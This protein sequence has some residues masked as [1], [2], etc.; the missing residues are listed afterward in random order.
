MTP[1]KCKLPQL[2]LLL[3]QK[4]V[5]ALN[6][7]FQTINLRMEQDARGDCKLTPSEV[8]EL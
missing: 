5:A 8:S 3:I 6:E 1:N 4:Q 7:K 2:L